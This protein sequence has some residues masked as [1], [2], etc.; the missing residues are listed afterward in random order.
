[1]EWTDVRGASGYERINGEIWLYSHQGVSF[2]FVVKRF[3]E[4]ALEYIEME[5]KRRYE[6]R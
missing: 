5:E 1:M 4:Y 3:H 6:P 2:C